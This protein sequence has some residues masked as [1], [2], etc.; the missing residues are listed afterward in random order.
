VPAHIA[1]GSNVV[2][3][4]HGQ[5]SSGAQRFAASRPTTALATVDAVDVALL[6]Q[7]RLMVGGDE[8]RGERMVA[9]LHRPPRERVC[10]IEQSQRLL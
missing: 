7:H 8:Q 10:P 6:E 5:S 3:S 2:T 4:V 9:G 1:H